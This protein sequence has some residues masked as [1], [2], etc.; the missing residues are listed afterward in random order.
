MCEQD[1]TCAPCNTT[2]GDGL[3]LQR[4]CS[5][6]DTTDVSI[7]TPC[8]NLTCPAS[9][10]VN[11]T[12][13]RGTANLRLGASNLCTP[14]TV[15]NSTEYEEQPCTPFSDRVCKPCTV[16]QVRT[17]YFVY[18]QFHTFPIHMTFWDGAGR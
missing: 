18:K 10:F 3:Y 16:C 15:C 6:M 1:L 7:C 13:C 4:Q 11:L 12:K 17:V 5:G 14:C 2:C 9:Q 8:S